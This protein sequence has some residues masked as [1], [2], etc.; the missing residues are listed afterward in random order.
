MILFKQKSYL[1][2]NKL[3]YHIL[4]KHAQLLSQF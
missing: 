3:T 2:K 1:N 4:S